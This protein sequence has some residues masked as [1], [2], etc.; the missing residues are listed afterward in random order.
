MPN[1]T[2]AIPEELHKKMKRHSEMKWSEVARQ[3]FERKINEIELMNKLPEESKL[4][5]EAVPPEGSRKMRRKLSKA[6]APQPPARKGIVIASENPNSKPKKSKAASDVAV[7]EINTKVSVPAKTE[8]KPVAVA[9]K[10]R[11]MPRSASK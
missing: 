8:K 1:M 11:R 6:I 7:A 2:L 5:E 4:S 10:S 9:R 3:A